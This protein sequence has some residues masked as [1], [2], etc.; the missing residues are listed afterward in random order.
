ME[1]VVK[2]NDVYMLI[3]IG[4]LLDINAISHVKLAIKS[5]ILELFG[6]V[7]LLKVHYKILKVIHNTQLFILKT[8]IRWEEYTENIFAFR[9]L[10]LLLYV[11]Q[12]SQTKKYEFSLKVLKISNFLANL[13]YS[14][15]SSLQF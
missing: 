10:N 2:A 7:M 1:L 13:T 11:M 5:I 15:N 8:D 9:F 6:L 12:P 4:N 14:S 3:K